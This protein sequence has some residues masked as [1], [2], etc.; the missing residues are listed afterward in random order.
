MIEDGISGSLF[1][2][3][4]SDELAKIL[5]WAIKN[6]GKTLRWLQMVLRV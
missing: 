4:N 1:E 5:A 2:P 3:K 6:E